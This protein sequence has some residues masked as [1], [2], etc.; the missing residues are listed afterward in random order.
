MLLLAL[1]VSITCL[2]LYVRRVKRIL[3]R[4]SKPLTYFSDIM[5]HGKT[6]LITGG[7][8]GIGKETALDLAGRGSRV[9]LA[10][11]NLTKAKETAEEIKNI[12]RNSN[13][14]TM[15]LDLNDLESV[16]KFAQRINQNEKRLDIL[17][18]NAGI[19]VRGSD[20]T[21]Q[22]YDEFFGI[23]YL[24]H[25]LL[26]YLLLDLLKKSAPSR[27]IN[28]SSY[29]H[30]FVKKYPDFYLGQ[31]GAKI[32][33]PNLSGYATSKLCNILHSKILSKKLKA[34]QV[35]S[36]SLHPG[37]VKTGILNNDPFQGKGLLR[38]LLYRILFKYM[39]RSTKD[40]AKTV[41]YAAIDESLND[42]SGQYFE[43]NS[44]ANNELS[45]LAKDEKLA[46]KLWDIS[47]QMCAEYLEN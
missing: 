46:E 18:N 16:K 40:G 11:R 4:H 29:A 21:K 47:L 14:I 5:L 1:L 30:I 28:I 9:I 2:V 7:N 38:I 41:I 25:F 17:I 23:N 35:I 31:H 19:G 6:V 24:G 39:G 33:Y 10:C 13:I 45:K 37:M 34:S 15:E 42:I 43:N 22:N 3:S 44:I 8:S 26:T 20:C 12:T 27:I 32:K 36:N